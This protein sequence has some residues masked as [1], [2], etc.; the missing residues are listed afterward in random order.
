MIA[1][2]THEGSGVLGT[3]GTDFDQ[4]CGQTDFGVPE[5]SMLIDHD[6]FHDR[7]TGVLLVQQQG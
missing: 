1:Q 5:T 7:K 4:E 2:N 3:C 6:S